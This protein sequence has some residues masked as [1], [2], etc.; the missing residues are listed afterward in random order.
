MSDVLDALC[1][2]VRT[3]REGREDVER[4]S[5]TFLPDRDTGDQGRYRAR[6]RVDG[7][8]V[9]TGPKGWTIAV[10]PGEHWIRVRFATRDG[11]ETG[12]T[13]TI[14]RTVLVTPGDRV[15]MA[16]GLDREAEQAHRGHLVRVLWWTFCW[17][18]ATVAAMSA[19]WLLYPLLHE[20]VARLVIRLG[21]SGR[22]MRLA[23]LPV[24]SPL[25]AML[26]AGISC[27]I[28]W[29]VS[30]SPLRRRRDELQSRYPAMFYV[31]PK[32]KRPLADDEFGS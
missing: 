15:V 3:F 30:G 25:R 1:N 16:C 11:L 12:K 2:R 31:E 28:L 32:G 8:L 27:Q 6:V 10:E 24:G 29:V 20:A 22:L 26:F 17:W 19:V 5:I 9:A 7:R 14:R 13:A 4:A 23:Y 21:L 18:I